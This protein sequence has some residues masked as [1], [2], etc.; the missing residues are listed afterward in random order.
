MANSL[1]EAITEDLKTFAG[2]GNAFRYGLETAGPGDGKALEMNKKKLDLE[3]YVKE[4]F[5]TNFSLGLVEERIKDLSLGQMLLQYLKLPE[6]QEQIKENDNSAFYRLVQMFFT[7]LPIKASLEEIRSFYNKVGNPAEDSE[8]RLLIGKLFDDIED[9]KERKDKIDELVDAI[10]SA[11]TNTLIRYNREVTV[12]SSYYRNKCDYVGLGMSRGVLTTGSV[13][14]FCAQNMSGGEIHADSIGNMACQFM[15]GGEIHTKSV[16]DV[17]GMLM[18]GGRIYAGSA[19]EKF[20]WCASGGVF[21]VGYAGSDLANGSG[22]AIFMVYGDYNYHL[23]WNKTG[24]VFITGG[25]SSPLV[26]GI[27]YTALVGK[28]RFGTA[29]Q[30]AKTKSTS[31]APIYGYDEKAGYFDWLHK[32]E[33][34]MISGDEELEKWK[35]KE[36]GLCVIYD[37][38][39]ISGDPTTGLKDGIM[40]LRAIPEG[41]ICAQMEGGAVILEVPGLTF[42]EAR[43]RVK[44][45]RGITGV[46]FMR[47]FDEKKPGQTKLIEV[48]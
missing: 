46:V 23:P 11:V 16:A 5:K 30:A 9:K 8:I 35:E 10:K 12:D 27:K 4:Y 29:E 43:K 36:R 34:Q 40:V 45:D 13:G 48:K 2:F 22:K 3:G 33:P 32:E 47:M 17:T 15:S 20:G 26:G 24:G 25:S 41:E 31:K 18:R 39:N 37:L 19:G 1:C 7:P 44:M 14:N 21:F 6:V 28:M 38:K 42:E